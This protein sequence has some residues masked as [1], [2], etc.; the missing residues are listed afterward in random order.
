[1]RGR[2]ECDGEKRG[3]IRYGR[4][5]SR[6][7]GQEIEQ[8]Y[9]VMGNG[10]LGVATRRSQMP[11]KQELPRT[12]QGWHWLKYPT[13]GRENLLRPYTEVRHAPLPPTLVEGWGHP[14]ISKILTQNCSCLKEI[15]K[16]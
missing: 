11:V 2:E 6:C 4:R 16:E 13:K 1:L 9:V 8:R 15:H 5:W 14:P 7:M 3:R 10:K 12:P